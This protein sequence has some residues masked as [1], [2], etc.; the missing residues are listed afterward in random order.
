MAHKK[1]YHEK[2]ME[3][4]REI[5]RHLEEQSIP[6]PIHITVRELRSRIEWLNSTSSVIYRV[7][8]L[9]DIGY[10]MTKEDIP[11]RISSTSVMIVINK[12]GVK[13]A[14]QIER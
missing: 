13:K 14:K 11:T 10:L 6:Y 9:R 2:N 1:G 8:L 4:L 7:K 3:V 5:H 12:E